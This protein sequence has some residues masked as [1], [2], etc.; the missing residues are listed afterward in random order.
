MSKNFALD[1]KEANA[2]NVANISKLASLKDEVTFA[3]RCINCLSVHYVLCFFVFFSLLAGCDAS[4]NLLIIPEP[5]FVQCKP[6]NYEISDEIHISSNHS[7]LEE[8]VSYIQ[9]EIFPGASVLSHYIPKRHYMDE[10]DIRFHIDSSFNFQ[11]EGYELDVSF[12]G[13]D[14]RARTAQGAFW[15]LQTLKQLSPSSAG[16]HHTFRCSYIRDFPRFSYRGIHLDVARHMFSI[17]DIKKWINTIAH[18]KINTFHWHLTDDQG[19]RIEIKKHPKLH[20]IGGYRQETLKGHLNN[21]VPH[22][23]DHT[24]YGGY[25]TQDEIREVVEYARKRHIVV[26]PEIEMPGHAVAALAAYPKLGC[27]TKKYQTA[28]SW[29]I[30]EDVF[31]A[32]KEEVFTFLEDVLTEV[33]SLFPSKYIHI[34]ADEV[35]KKAWKKCSLCQQRMYDEHLSDECELQSYFVKR[36]EKFLNSNGR[37][38]IGWDEILEGGLAPN[39]TVMSWRGIEKGVEAAKQNHHAIMVPN[40][41]LYFDYYQGPG[42][43]E[44]LAIGGLTTLDRVYNYEPIPAGLAPHLIPYIIGVQANIW[45]EYMHDAS[46]VEYM[47]F[48]RALAL[49]EMGWSQRDKRNYSLFKS[50]LGKHVKFLKAHNINHKSL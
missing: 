14:I 4:Q 10:S 31:C 8:V 12:S 30:F 37:S 32:G 49:A 3:L 39:S 34:G 1:L 41:F 7:S 11:D 6:G 44:P 27:E 38:L 48:P 29:G 26:I 23:F 2:A 33:L 20:L 24:P 46:H 43:Q 28:C 36:I 47:A 45:T 9:S 42:E 17:Q 13:I 5:V 21:D 50:K 19:W 18:Y 22:E 15:A 40:H 35:P 16:K 25:Y